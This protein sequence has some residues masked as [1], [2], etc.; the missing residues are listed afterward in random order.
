MKTINAH[1]LKNRLDSADDTIVIDVLPQKYYQA[2]HIPGAANIPLGTERF[3]EAVE[4]SVDNTSRPVVVYCASTECDLSPN[5]AERLEQSGFV[6]V[7]DFEGGLAEWKA[8]GF[9]VTAG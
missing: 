7:I 5:A 8:A 3:V 9:D 6:D 2:E 1:D 4:R